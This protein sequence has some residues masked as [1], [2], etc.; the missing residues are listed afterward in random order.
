MVV[1][2][3][4]DKSVKIKVRD[5][6]VKIKVRDH[7]SSILSFAFCLLSYHDYLLDPVKIII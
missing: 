2:K 1:K 4:K 7:F 6:S 5:K 3:I